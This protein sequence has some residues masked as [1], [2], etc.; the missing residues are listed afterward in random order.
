MFNNNNY[1][2]EYAR[3]RR[4][5]KR[6]LNLSYRPLVRRIRISTSNTAQKSTRELHT[7]DVR[8]RKIKGQISKKSILRRSAEGAEAH[9]FLIPCGAFGAAGA[10]TPQAHE[11]STLSVG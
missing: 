4:T 6:G 1:V 9:D 2:Q 3:T 10:E 11:Y 7:G 5:P 8:L